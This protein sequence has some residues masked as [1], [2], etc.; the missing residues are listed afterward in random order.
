MIEET[1]LE[2]EEK[3]D[4]AVE[5]AKE[6]FASIRTGRANPGLYN[7][8]LVDYYGSPTPLQQLASF[9]IPDA[10]TILITPFDKTSLRDIERALSDSEVGANPSNDGNVIRI[11][12]PDLTQERRKEY[13]KIVKTKGEDAK[14]SIRNIRRKAKETLDKLVKD[15]EAGEDEG[16]RAEKELDAL[17]KSHVDGIDELLKRKEAELLEV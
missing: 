9:A 15:G 2:A 12:I 11:T 10:R 8:V 17:T 6:D 1:L 13:V 14:I 7:K 16:N 5:V 4:K 3:M